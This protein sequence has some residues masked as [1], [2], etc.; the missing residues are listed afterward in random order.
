L[1]F[2]DI[3]SVRAFLASELSKCGGAYYEY[4]ANAEVWEAE[5]E[6]PVA[7]PVAVPFEAHDPTPWK[8]AA[9]GEAH[10][11]YCCDWRWPAGTLAFR[12]V[13]LARRIGAAQD[14]VGEWKEK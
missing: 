14:L 11:E 6:E 2:C 8:L 1:V 7:L 13:R 3:E 5:A 9:L 12:R 4:F 10:L